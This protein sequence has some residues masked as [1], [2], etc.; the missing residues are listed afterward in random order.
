V[1]DEYDPNC[2]TEDMTADS[3]QVQVFCKD[4][5]FT[6]PRNLTEQS[7]DAIYVLRVAP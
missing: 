4:L 3:D 6:A 7:S 1:T 5:V 2:H